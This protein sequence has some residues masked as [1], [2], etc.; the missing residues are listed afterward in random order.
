MACLSGAGPDSLYYCCGFYYF[1]FRGARTRA[2]KFL[3]WEESDLSEQQY[4]LSE[5]AQSVWAIDQMCRWA[6]SGRR[7]ARSLISIILLPAGGVAAEGLF[8]NCL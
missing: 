5:D 3:P 7:G 1:V 8:L 4:L 6:R 2:D